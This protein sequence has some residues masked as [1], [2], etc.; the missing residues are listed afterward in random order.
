MMDALINSFVEDIKRRA[1]LYPDDL[2]GHMLDQATEA[3][4]ECLLFSAT[5]PNWI[6][7]SD[8]SKVLIEA[9]F[10]GSRG[11]DRLNY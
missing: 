10:R 3:D 7:R 11:L 5:F 1:A 8:G 2:E 4:G 9:K 6:K